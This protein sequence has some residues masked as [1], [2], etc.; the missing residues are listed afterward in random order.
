MVGSALRPGAPA[1]RR[2]E[3]VDTAGSLEATG[4]E[5]QARLLAGTPPLQS[6]SA[7]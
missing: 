1:L 4:T 7:H 5:L 2:A 3:L 6:F